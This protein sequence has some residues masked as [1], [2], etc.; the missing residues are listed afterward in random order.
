MPIYGECGGLM[1]LGEELVMET[2][3]YRM[4]G[5]LPG[6]TVMTRKLVAL[7]YARAE[8]VGSNP[9]AGMGRSI[10]GHEFHYSRF[11]CSR[12][13]RFAY[14]MSRGKGIQ[15][16]QD[17]LVAEGFATIFCQPFFEE[18]TPTLSGRPSHLPSRK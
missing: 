3:R 14:R 15:D 16:G 2:G 10:L 12:D 18:V 4:V 9:L 11:D 6:S 8:V 1:Y 7:G 5:A 13:A 17:G